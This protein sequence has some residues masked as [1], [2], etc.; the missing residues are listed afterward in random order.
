MN[1]TRYNLEYIFLILTLILLSVITKKICCL[2]NP[3][4]LLSIIICVL[5][6][7]LDAQ[8]E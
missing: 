5:S 3:T 8:E 6:S 1:N 4:F 7:F 2:V